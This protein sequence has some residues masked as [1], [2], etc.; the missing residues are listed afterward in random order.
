[1]ACGCSGARTGARSVNRNELKYIVATGRNE[2]NQPICLVDEEYNCRYFDSY[3]QAN[4]HIQ[5]NRIAGA[6]AQ[7][8]SF[9]PQAVVE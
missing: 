4:K 3:Q 2:R 7:Q 1:M 9:A 6:W 8:V 5:D